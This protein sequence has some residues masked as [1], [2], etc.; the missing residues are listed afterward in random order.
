MTLFKRIRAFFT[1]RGEPVE[2]ELDRAEIKKERVFLHPSDDPSQT[3]CIKTNTV[4]LLINANEELA[5]SDVMVK[6][7]HNSQKTKTSDKAAKNKEKASSKSGKGS[8][9]ASMMPVSNELDK[10]KKKRVVFMLYPEEYTMVMDSIQSN[11]Y[12]KN[13]YFLAC[14][15]SAKKQSMDAAYKKYLYSHKQLRKEERNTRMTA[16]Q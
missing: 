16:A 10:Y 15:T 11:G 12:K 4:D 13:E 5:E 2:M 7:S 8:D 1:F 9:S 3:Y 14:V 6:E